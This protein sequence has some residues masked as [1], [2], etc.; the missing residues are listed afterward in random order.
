[1][2]IRSE[3]DQG[4]KG[5]AIGKEG[6][7]VNVRKDFISDTKTVRPNQPAIFRDTTTIG[8]APAGHLLAV[9]GTTQHKPL[10]GEQLGSRRNFDFCLPADASPIED[11]CL[12]R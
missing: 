8:Y 5:F 1:L 9:R 6:I 2:E 3:I 12:L 7:P 10:D 4:G 11:D